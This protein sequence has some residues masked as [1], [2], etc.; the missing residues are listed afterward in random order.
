MRVTLL[1]YTKDAE[2]LC[3]AAAHSCYSEKPASELMDEWTEKKGERWLGSPL[4]S[5]HHSVI[6]HAN[7]TFSI[8]GVSRATTHQLVRHRLA[9]FSQQSQR[10]VDMKNA[11]YVVPESIAADPE[12]EKRFRALMDKIW[13][14]YRALSEKVPVE[15]ARYVLPNA[16]TTNITVTMNARELW[17]FFEL[18]TCR[19]AQDEIR[20]VADEMLRLAQEASPFIFKRAGPPC[21][22]KGKCSEGRMSCGKPRTELKRA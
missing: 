10:Y 21:I 17:H 2:R 15:D 1:S 5:G 20:A 6:E 8:E 14:E 19:R 7:Y 11:E 18:R 22:S 3:A 13:E 9:S 12:L 4:D 16:C